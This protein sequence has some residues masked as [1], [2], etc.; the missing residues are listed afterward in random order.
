MKIKTFMFNTDYM[1]P[2]AGRQDG[3]HVYACDV[4]GINEEIDNTVN[5]FCK[6]KEVIEIN[7]TTH[8]QGNNPPSTFM[9]VTVIYSQEINSNNA[10]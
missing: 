8:V 1:N 7:V 3:K 10:Q 6:D 5:D 2:Y 9:D 4:R